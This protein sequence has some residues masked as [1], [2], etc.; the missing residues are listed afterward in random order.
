MGNEEQTEA[1]QAAFKAKVALAAFKGDR[2]ASG[3]Q[4]HVLGGRDRL[5]QPLHAA[6][7]DAVAIGSSFGWM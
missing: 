6:L 5:V 4:L 3:L 7:M 2:T 1:F